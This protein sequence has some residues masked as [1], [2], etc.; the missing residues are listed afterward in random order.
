M[1]KKLKILRVIT[2]IY[3]D[4]NTQGLQE[5]TLNHNE[6]YEKGGVCMEQLHVATIGCL[7]ERLSFPRMCSTREAMQNDSTLLHLNVANNRIHPPELMELIEGIASNCSLQRLR[8]G[9][10][11]NTAKSTTVIL[12][13]IQ[14][15]P[16]LQLD[17][18]DQ[19]LWL[20]SHS[21]K[22]LD[23]INEQR[24]AAC[25]ITMDESRIMLCRFE[26]SGLRSTANYNVFM[27]STRREFE[28]LR[29]WIREYFHSEKQEF[30]ND[31]IA[32]HGAC[33]LLCSV[34]KTA[35]IKA[36]KTMEYGPKEGWKIKT[37][38]DSRDLEV[39]MQ[40]F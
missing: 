34:N 18:L 32:R 19:V 24:R 10:N 21:K 13:V 11:R 2:I 25:G 8:L 39:K 28:S 16:N 3:S 36:E 6:I 27:G 35:K 14:N 20:M 33:A 23:A 30:T 9:P 17:L 31:D 38:L 4:Q 26:R 29:G 12:A 37:C 1:S 7:M 15:N 22:I 5:M 40:G